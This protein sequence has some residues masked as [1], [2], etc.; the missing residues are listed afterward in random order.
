MHNITAVRKKYFKY[1][2][3]NARFINFEL[4]L[5]HK[6]PISYYYIYL[7]YIDNNDHVCY[8]NL[9]RYIIECEVVRTNDKY[10]SQI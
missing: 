1:L 7:Y 5:I 8:N 3:C 4:L 6:G 10:V 9:Q 2:D